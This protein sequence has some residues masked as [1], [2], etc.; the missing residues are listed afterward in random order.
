MSQDNQTEEAVRAEFSDFSGK[1]SITY[2]TEATVPLLL[3]TVRTIP[4]GSVI[5]Y[6]WQ[7][8]RDRGS[9]MYSDAIARLVADAAK[10]PSVRHQRYVHR[11]GR[12][13]WRDARNAGDRDSNWRYGAARPR[14]HAAPGHSHRER[15][16]QAGH[17]LAPGAAVGHRRFSSSSW[18]ANRISRALG[19]GTLPLLY[20]RRRDGHFGGDCIDRRADHPTNET[21]KSRTAGASK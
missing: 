7:T 9:V 12:R 6:I 20:C 15:A 21:E 18:I 19:L 5:L 3:S 1:V 13:R 4:Q 16:R 2:V 8:Q 14:W 10:V 11:D 17:R